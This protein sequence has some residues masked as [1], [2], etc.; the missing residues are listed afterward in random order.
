MKYILNSVARHVCVLCFLTLLSMVQ[1]SQST[2]NNLGS[3][4]MRQ[5]WMTPIQLYSLTDDGASAFISQ[6]DIDEIKVAV[7][8]H[9]KSFELAKLQKDVDATTSDMF[10]MYQ[11]KEDLRFKMCMKTNSHMSNAC[12]AT[13]PALYR[14]LLAPIFQQAAINYLK[15]CYLD[16]SAEAV[17]LQQAQS[18]L[19]PSANMFIWSSLHG[20]GS[21]H[22][23]H[24]HKDSLLSGILYIDTPPGSGAVVFADPRGSLPPFG[25]TLQIEP[26]PG[27]LIL[28]PS[29]LMHSVLPTLSRDPRISVSFN[30]NGQWEATSDI[31]H[32]F[33]V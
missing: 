33:Y 22:S 25:T 1:Y 21:Y 26:K 14:S 6:S 16:D 18:A 11:Q 31:N 30:Y 4:L 15:E 12:V 9:Y 13:S 20:N 5:M 3:S 7:L 28:F 23:P 29:W 32:G 8:N 19:D 24:H 17:R 2:E 27:N 10:Y